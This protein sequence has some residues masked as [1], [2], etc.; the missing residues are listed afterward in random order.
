METIW[1]TKLKY[2]LSGPSQKKS[3]DPRNIAYSYPYI[4]FDFLLLIFFYSILTLWNAPQI[5]H[6]LQELAS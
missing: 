5:L 6:N 2:L 3:A 4:P 1:P